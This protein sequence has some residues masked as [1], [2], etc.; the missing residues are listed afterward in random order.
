MADF[1]AS[2]LDIGLSLSS[3]LLFVAGTLNLAGFLL[4]V[5][6]G[7][8]DI[9]IKMPTFLNLIGTA[10]LGLAVSLAVMLTGSEQ[11]KQATLLLSILFL[12]SGTYLGLKKHANRYIGSDG[13]ALKVTLSG[14]HGL[15]SKLKKRGIHL[16]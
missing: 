5:R 10:L 6:S 3:A 7:E 1:V 9:K 8:E 14:T 12:L 2:F 13:D 4:Q 15:R 11:A 16:R